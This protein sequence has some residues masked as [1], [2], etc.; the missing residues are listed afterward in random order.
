MQLVVRW[1]VLIFFVAIGV[2]SLLALLG[3][4]RKV[5]PQFR[6][7]AVTGF[8]A[9]VAGNIF[10]LFR[11]AKVVLFIPLIPPTGHGLGPDLVDGAYSYTEPGRRGPKTRSGMVEVARGPGGYQAI[12][13]QEALDKAVALTFHDKAGAEWIVQPFFPNY[14]RQQLVK[15]EQPEAALE[16]DQP[17]GD[18]DAPA[19]MLAGLSELGASRDKRAAIRFDNYAKPAAQQTQDRRVYEWRLFVDEPPD[20]LDTIQEVDYLLHPTFPQPFQVSQDRANQFEIV[21]AGWGGFNV[22]IT[23]HFRDGKQAKTT[24]RLDLTKGWPR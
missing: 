15:N 23:V 12:L 1:V 14:N 3:F 16:R 22:Q 2:I 13:P 6:K 17:R 4:P 19:V 10:W 21:G 5:D 18:P 24:Y 7:W 11:L 8:C 9:G 20:V